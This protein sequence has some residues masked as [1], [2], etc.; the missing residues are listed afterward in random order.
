MPLIRHS[1][2]WGGQPA[3]VAGINRDHAR[4]QGL[5]FFA[6]L[7]NDY[8]FREL[9]SGREMSRTGYVTDAVV[10][11]VRT[12]LFGASSYLG[13]TPPPE[14]G[15]TTPFTLAW[16]QQYTAAVSY[17]TLLNV[18]FGT[19]GVDRNFVLYQGAD[20]QY[21]FVIGPR[22][23]SSVPRWQQIGTPTNH[24]VD[25]YVL[26]CL[27]GSQAFDIGDYVLWRNGEPLTATHTTVLTLATLALNRLG[28]RES[29]TDPFEGALLD[30]R[31]W[32]GI[33]P[34]DE[35]AAE[36]RLERVGD[37]Y[38][39]A[40]IWVPVS[41]GTPSLPTLSALTTKPGTLTSTGF[42]TRVTAS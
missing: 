25:R 37:L 14:I 42:T 9:V 28:A 3:S 5:V 20:S 40:P 13:F 23:G 35:A 22:R 7:G 29:G 10:N 8:G 12:K 1:W 19:A 24:R 26:Q 18:Q 2:P 39:P 6:P 16:T 41:A 21:N 4:A 17:N 27:G 38:G 30:L 11:G 33:L 34:D 15:P 31:M 36:S 32:V